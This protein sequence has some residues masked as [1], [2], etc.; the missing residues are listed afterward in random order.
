MDEPAARQHD[1]IEVSVVIPSYNT[2]G[3]IGGCLRSVLAQGDDERRE[4]IAVDSA[5]DGTDALVRREFP[6]VRLLRRTART[7]SGIARNIGARQARGEVLAFLAADCIAGPGW[8]EE[9]CRFH[10]HRNGEPGRAADRPAACAGSIANGTPGSPVGTAEWLVEFSGAAPGLPPHEVS[11][12]ATANL[13]LPRALL[14]ATPGFDDSPPGQEMVFG[15]ALRTLGSPTG[16]K[17]TPAV[18]HRN[19]TRPG[20]SLPRPVARG[21]H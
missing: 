9:V 19:R 2:R 16:L 18:A 20:A 4:V 3:T 15:N 21:G 7:H 14:L 17:R 1:A 11:F 5:D 10:G 8:L 6:Q 12:G 13:S